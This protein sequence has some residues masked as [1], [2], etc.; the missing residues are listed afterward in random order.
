MKLN[1]ILG[2]GNDLIGPMM[3]LQEEEGIPEISLPFPTE[4]MPCEDTR[5]QSSESQEECC[6]QKLIR[7]YHDLGL[8]P[9]S[10]MKK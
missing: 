3:F 10:I 8:P 6:H 5:S 2:W 9:S 1:K 4:E 7:W